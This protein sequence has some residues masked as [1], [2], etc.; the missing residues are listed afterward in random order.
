MAAPAAEFCY[1]Y[2][3]IHALAE[4]RSTCEISKLN[5]RSTEQALDKAL[6]TKT[7]S[8]WHDKSLTGAV[9]GFSFILG[10]LIAGAVK[11]P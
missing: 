1:T 3:E 5:L 4:Y 2:E 6:Q 9:A 10:I 11:N 7:D 8:V